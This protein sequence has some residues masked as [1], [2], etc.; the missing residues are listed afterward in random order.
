MVTILLLRHGK[1]RWDEAGAADHDRGLAP[2]GVTAAKAMG[3]HA[4]RMGWL[5]ERVLCSTAT[6]TVQTARLFLEGAQADVAVEEV[7]AI[8]EASAATL[9]QVLTG[10]AG[11]GT[12]LLV[13]HMPG[14]PA[15]AGRLLRDAAE[16]PNKFPTAGLAVVEVGVPEFGE[17]RTGGG[18]LVAFVRP[19]EL[20]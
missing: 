6:R 16:L 8:Y 5:P 7:A 10:Q 2:R 19:R 13:G 1:S 20:H 12:L 11:G 3:R 4:A 18:E 17:V 14:L 9:M 15:L